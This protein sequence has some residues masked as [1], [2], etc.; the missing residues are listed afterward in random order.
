[1]CIADSSISTDVI[2]VSYHA[3]DTFPKLTSNNFVINPLPV[4]D[5]NILSG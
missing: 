2:A 4:A 5:I 1:M 3:E